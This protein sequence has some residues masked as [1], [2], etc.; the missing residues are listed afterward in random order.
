M[1]FLDIENKV[2]REEL[3]AILTFKGMTRWRDL[4]KSFDD[5]MTKSDLSYDKIVSIFTNG[6]PAMMVKEKR[7][8]KRIRDINSSMHNSSNIVLS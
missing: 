6:A 5:L 4:F 2:F 1:R 3:L 8:L 7:L